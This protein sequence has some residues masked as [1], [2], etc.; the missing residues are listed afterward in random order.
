MKKLF[1]LTAIALASLSNN[2]QAQTYDDVYDVHNPTPVAPSIQQPRNYNDGNSTY[3]DEQ[4][5][6]GTMIDYNDDDYYYSSYINRFYS[7]TPGFGYFSSCYNNPFAWGWGNSWNNWNSPY[8]LNGGFG[9]GGIYVNYGYNPW[10]SWNSPY[11]NNYNSWGYNPWNSYSYNNFGF[12]GGYCGWGNNFNNYFFSNNYNGWGCGNNFY[13]GGYGGY[14]YNQ[15]FYDGYYSG[16]Y[17][18]NNNNNW[19]GNNGNN[20]NGGKQY[21]AYHYG[22]RNSS[23]TFANLAEFKATREVVGVPI[24]SQEKNPVGSQASGNQVG[25]RKQ[26]TNRAPGA[27][28]RINNQRMGTIET[29]PRQIAPQQNGGRNNGNAP[30]VENNQGRQRFNGNQPQQDRNLTLPEGTQRYEAP[31]VP[32]RMPRNEAP[33]PQRQEPRYE[34]P[35][36]REPRYEAP[37]APRYEAPAPQREEPRYEAPQ[38]REPRYEAPPAP[39]YEAPAPQREEPRYEAPQRREPRYEA[40]PAPRYEAPAPQREAPSRSNDNTPSRSFG[41]RR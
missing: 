27:E 1:F 18:N 29:A 12:G 10:N 21:D 26:F 13:G 40:P 7:P 11:C 32:R 17:A 41:G 19:G 30:A 31:P 5:Y 15:G 16:Y 9:W 36:R 39:R 37:P 33:T 2:A 8:G 3:Y 4:G 25:G 35:Q 28:D 24:R 23:Y 6:S 20:G 38:R 14:G 34:A 22:P